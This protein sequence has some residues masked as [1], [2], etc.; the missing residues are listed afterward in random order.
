MPARRPGT[1]PH[2]WPR[3]A[4]TNPLAARSRYALEPRRGRAEAI[5]ALGR[6]LCIVV[7][8]GPFVPALAQGEA[9]APPG[10]K[11]PIEREAL[12]QALRVRAVDGYVVSG[13]DLRA[14]LQAVDGRVQLSRCVIEG[15]LQLPR[16]VAARLEIEDCTI[17]AAPL[18]R[19]LWAG[20]AVYARG[21]RFAE[22]VKLSNTR[23]AGPAVFEGAEFGRRASFYQ[24][25]LE[26]GVDASGAVFSSGADFL[27]A[28][29]ENGR[30]DGARFEGDTSFS[31]ALIGE[32]SSFE[33]AEFQGSTR[34]ARTTFTG[35]VQLAARFRAPVSFREARFRS[36]AHFAG[37]TGRAAFQDRVEFRGAIFEGAAVF[38]GVAF[39]GETDFEG[40]SFQSAVFT[41]GSFER[42]VSF[43]GAAFPGP[44]QLQASF[45]SRARF[46]EARF[47]SD[48]RFSRASDDRDAPVARFGDEADFSA[49]VFAGRA[50][51]EGVVFT[52][53][54]VF[55]GADFRDSAVF[56]DVDF[57]RAAYFNVAR[58]RGR[59]GFHNVKAGDSITFAE[60]EL[61]GPASFLRAELGG[62]ARFTEARFAERAYFA[63]A[64]FAGDAVFRAARFQG[65]AVFEDVVFG[66]LVDLQGARVSGSLSLRNTSYGAYADLR[67]A[68]IGALDLNSAERPSIVAA[69][70]DMRG[71]RVGAAHLEDVIFEQN[72]DFS[73]AVFG[74]GGSAEARRG[75]VFRFVTFESPAA[76]ARGRFEGPVVLENVDF[77]NIADFTDARFASPNGSGPSFALSYVDFAE[78]RVHW[79]Q[80]PPPSVWVQGET[81]RIEPPFGD[82]PLPRQLEPRSR[83][84]ERL[85]G[86]FR[87]QG[88][89]ADANRAYYHRKRTEL[90]EARAEGFTWPRLWLEAQWIL[91]GATAGYGTRLG[92]IV[93]WSVLMDVLFALVYWRAALIQREPHP[94]TE[95]EHSF[96]LRLLDLP[97]QYLTGKSE[98]MVRSKLVDALRGSSVILLKVGYRDTTLSGG[99]GPIKV[100]YLV[101]LEWALGYLVLAALTVTLA[102]TQPLLNRLLTG[103]F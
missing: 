48:A 65:N 33:G 11:G 24:S 21:T 97:K 91:W 4:A 30:F 36:D 28:R 5:H 80:L 73:D 1:K 59:A 72:V 82:A 14:A 70:F 50:E 102:N 27:G 57:R 9:A 58:F 63:E 7:L 12:I 52:G 66:G 42:D 39:E 83:V 96:R 47:G 86:S 26:E 54:A 3:G 77:Q 29:V 25:E 64:V 93:G 35:E 56:H 17:E 100:G 16:T 103:I 20:T 43:A 87:D 61:Q 18:T 51:L 23:V 69:R 98:R 15:G 45:R 71:A 40:A 13:D 67:E 32:G 8:L 41:G 49:A 31:R 89:L 22:D 2:L 44:A 62:T 75:T 95:R 76:F 37:R 101:R 55:K 85:E 94:E 90:L 99:L 6:L 46:E 84:L 19:A 74:V 81:G 78:L 34:F 60:A 10:H 92:W 88:Q 53:T 79:P 68:R 38:E